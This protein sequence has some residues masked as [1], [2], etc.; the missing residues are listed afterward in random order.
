[1]CIVYLG[2][3]A[4]KQLDTLEARRELEPKCVPQLFLGSLLETC[5]SAIGQLFYLSIV[6]VPEVFVNAA[7]LSSI[8]ANLFDENCANSTHSLRK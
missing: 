7:Q 1:M 8:S 4:G 2:Q 5:Q 3:R 6:T